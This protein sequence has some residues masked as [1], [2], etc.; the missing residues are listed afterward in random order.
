VD[1]TIINDGTTA[2]AG[3]DLLYVTGPNAR[4]S[5]ISFKDPRN[6]ADSGPQV[7]MQCNN[8][9][10]DYNSLTE[11]NPA[12]PIHG[13]VVQSYNGTNITGS[14][15]IDHNYF[16]SLN[17]GVNPH[18]D[19]PGEVVRGSQSWEHSMTPGD[20][21]A[22][23]VED[24]HFDYDQAYNGAYDA[25]DG[26][27]LVFRYNTVKNTNMGGHGFDSAMRATL[28]QE[29]YR[30]T[31]SNIA[32]PNG[33]IPV[34][35]QTRG[36]H[37]YVWEN[38][39]SSA[40]NSYSAHMVLTSY[41]SDPQGTAYVGDKGICGSDNYRD[42]NTPGQKGYPC[43]DQVG[44]GPSTD[45]A[46][47]WPTLT[48]TSVNSQVLMPGTPGGTP[49]RA[50]PRRFRRSILSLHDQKGIGIISDC[51]PSISSTIGTSTWKCR[52]LTGQLERAAARWRHDPLPVLKG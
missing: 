16:K 37:H 48:T 33:T 10:L 7:R 42:G 6:L 13:V 27:R 8:C 9:R 17:G 49:L 19:E 18:G 30:N 3:E 40:G 35:F 2:L 12:G 15:L 36:G 22:T 11:D 32:N 47:D 28:R 43:R 44:R 5:G 29:I 25:Y 38:N 23:Y 50:R 14:Q 21:K 26:A 39:I 1:G 24:N 20:E 31:M 45:P 41:R 52:V 46:N 4:V 51:V 34:W